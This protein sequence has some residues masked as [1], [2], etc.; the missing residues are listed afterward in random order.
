MIEAYLELLIS[1]RL[2]T[3][4]DLSYIN[5]EKASYVVGILCLFTACIILPSLM[6]YILCQTKETI[7][8]AHFTT[9]FGPLY[10]GV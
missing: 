3:Y 7:Q 10:E 1:G 5:G 9:K 4:E 2:G 6:I 8:S